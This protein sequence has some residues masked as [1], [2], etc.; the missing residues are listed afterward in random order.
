MVCGTENVAPNS[1]R[2]NAEDD[3][4]NFYR[5]NAD[6]TVPIGAFVPLQLDLIREAIAFI[7]DPKAASIP[8]FWNSNS[9][10]DLVALTHADTDHPVRLAL[11]FAAPIII[12]W[13]ITRDPLRVLEFA[14]VY[15][16]IV[17]FANLFWTVPL[18]ARIRGVVFLALVGSAWSARSR[19]SPTVSSFCL[20]GALLI[21]NA[22]GGVLTLAS[23][24]RPFSEGRNAAAWIKGNN[25]TDTFLIGS[26]DAQASTVAGYLGRP[27][28]YLECE[29]QGT[30]IA[31]NR[32]RQSLL[33]PQEFR[34]RLT[35]AIALAP[36]DNAILIRYQPIDD[37]TS[38][39]TN[40]DITLLKSFTD[41][42][43]TNENF[44]IYRVR[45]K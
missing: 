21:V 44:W 32:D 1:S 42:Q 35:R 19:H 39:E 16:G 27:I 24:L 6:L 30:F 12:C 40:L 43:S 11:L 45:K 33:S 18:G 5:L 38:N 36:Q 10:D 31:W 41:A 17:L 37:L 25:L 22:C 13:L 23:E 7:T 28:Y 8:K 34:D 2:L 26:R 4:S 15:L 20:L 29:C 9:T 14:L 3:A